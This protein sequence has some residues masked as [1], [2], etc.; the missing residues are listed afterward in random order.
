VRVEHARGGSGWVVTS[1]LSEDFSLEP[2]LEFKTSQFFRTAL[3]EAMPPSL[4]YVVCVLTEMLIFGHTLRESMCCASARMLIP[5]PCPGPL[6]R[7]FITVEGKP[8]HHTQFWLTSMFWLP[9]FAVYFSK[10]VRHYIEPLELAP[11]VILQACRVCVLSCK[12]A[13]LPVSYVGDV[14]GKL[15]RR[16]KGSDMNRTLVAAAW[17]DPKNKG[18]GDLLRMEL[19]NACLEADVDLL[20]TEV[21]LGSTHAAMVVRMR[22]RGVGERARKRV[23]TSPSVVSGKELLAAL[24]DT[25]VGQAAPRWL[26]LGIMLIGLIFAMLSPVGS[27]DDVY[28]QSSKAPSIYFTNPAR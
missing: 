11:M 9:I 17:N 19:E 6:K 23:N 3:Y 10:D 15:Y 13:L 4:G 22:A 2:N 12:Y 7:L 14:G 24:M 28:L 8:T 5:F 25:Y 1:A 26:P 27:V 21:N 18:H 16:M 20:D